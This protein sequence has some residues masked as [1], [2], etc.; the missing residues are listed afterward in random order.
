ML[1]RKA[2]ALT[3]IPEINASDTH[4]RVLSGGVVTRL[5]N[6]VLRNAARCLSPTF[7][8]TATNGGDG[9]L[10]RL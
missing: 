8:A 1:F 6:C 9:S 10:S 3:T 7:E 4:T 2:N 5:R